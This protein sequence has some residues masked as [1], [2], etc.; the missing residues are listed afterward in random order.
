MFDFSSTPGPM[1]M[2]I[3]ASSGRSALDYATTPRMVDLLLAFGA[4][5]NVRP[6]GSSA[7]HTAAH[8]NAIDIVRQLLPL[9]DDIEHLFD[10]HTF[11]PLHAAAQGNAVDALFFLYDHGINLDLTDDAGRTPLQLSIAYR[12]YEALEKLLRW[13]ANHLLENDH[14]W[15][16]IS[17]AGL[18]GDVTIYNILADFELDI[19][20]WTPMTIISEL[21]SAREWFQK[22]KCASEE[23]TSAFTWFLFSLE[24]GW[25]ED[26]KL[27]ADRVMELM[28][29]IL[30][31]EGLKDCVRFEQ[32]VNKVW[33][34]ENLEGVQELLC[35]LEREWRNVVKGSCR[36][37]L[38]L[39]WEV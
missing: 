20:T 23:L 37:L 28:G 8:N 25:N 21:F 5:L 18:H 1:P 19:S 16:L 3:K 32:L 38:D 10:D 11:T 9:A 34:D 31:N 22:R 30:K 2:S 24:T 14:G 12:S 29:K 4:E 39:M 13:K 7:L 33:E 15:R 27:V 6:D 35:L 36:K 26:E 17:Y